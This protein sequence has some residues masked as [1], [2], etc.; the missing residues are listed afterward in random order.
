[1]SR[2]NVLIVAVLFSITSCTVVS[3]LTA[4]IIGPI[5]VSNVLPPLPVADSANDGTS[6]GSTV[7]PV[8]VPLFE[9]HRRL[10]ISSP[11]ESPVVAIASHQS[12]LYALTTDGNVY[13]QAPGTGWNQTEIVVEASDRISPRIRLRHQLAGTTNRPNFNQRA[14]DRDL[15][16]RGASKHWLASSD[17]LIQWTKESNLTNIDELPIRGI[18][19]VLVDDSG[20]TWVATTQGLFTKAADKDWSQI[21]ERQGLPVEHTTCLASDN[22]GRIWIGTADGV[23]LF[24]PQATGRQWFYR[25]GQRYLPNDK[26][27]DLA[28][29]DDGRFIWALT[30]AGIGA[31][32]V[33][34]ATLQEKAQNIEEHIN[35]RHRR[36]GIVGETKFASPD[37]TDQYT[38]LPGPNDGLWTV[39]HVVAMSP[40]Y[41]VTGDEAAKTSAVTS[42]DALYMLQNAT[43]IPG[44]PARSVVPATEEK[45]SERWR[46]TPDKQYWWYTDTSSDE[47][48][49][50]YFAFYA[51]WEHI[52]RHDDALR[53]RHVRQVRELTDYIIENGY[54]L[55]DWDGE[56][57]R[58]GFWDPVSL[59]ENPLCYLENGL[60]SLEILSFLKVAQFVTGDNKYQQHYESLIVDH[61]YLDNVLLEKRVF[62]DQVNH[63]DDQLAYVAWYPLVQLEKDPQIRSVLRQSV[64]RHY[65]VEEPERASF[66]FFVTATIDPEVVDIHAA[67]DNLRNMTPDR[68]NWKVRNSHRADVTFSPRLDRFKKA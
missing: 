3:P 1:V 53:D 50:H 45:P 11:T 21:R 55:I 56:R 58:W 43:G 32:E 48:D 52:A 20:T 63:S 39:Y 28:I 40:S 25:A 35:D 7:L 46:L 22:K 62:P 12:K 5:K 54:R 60:N 44:L 29:S 9:E 4:K 18:N 31:I 36:L 68:R 47:I 42:M 27:I 59:N 2:L 67:I 8:E 51:F 19:D 61:G 49:G 10:D 37:D 66:F 38:I 14:N 16:I 26:V 57:T 65:L 23:V 24:Q 64:R 6:T 17:G 13:S 30:E 15:Q 41:A 33:R 34:T